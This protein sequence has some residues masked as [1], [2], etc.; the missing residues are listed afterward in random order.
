M[1]REH[2]ICIDVFVNS[3]CCKFTRTHKKHGFTVMYRRES[4]EIPTICGKHFL[5]QGALGLFGY[6]RK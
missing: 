6:I 4:Q 3:N 5:Y 2:E 1:G